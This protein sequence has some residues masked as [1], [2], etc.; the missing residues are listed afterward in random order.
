M[1]ARRLM[2]LARAVPETLLLVGTT[3]KVFASIKAARELLGGH[4]WSYDDADDPDS[5]PSGSAGGGGGRGDS[6]V[7]PNTAGGGGSLAGLGCNPGPDFWAD[8]L[9]TALAPDGPLP[10]AYCEITRLVSLHGEAGRVLV[11]CAARLGIQPGDA[12]NLG[13]GEPDGGAARVDLRPDDE[14]QAPWRRW[15]DLREAVVRHAHD[16][17]LALSSAA[18]AVA[19]AEDFMRWRYAGSPR[20]NEWVS[21]V[22]ELVRDARRSLGEAR[23]SVKLMR[24]A[25]VCQYFETWM[26]LNRA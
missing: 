19:A 22:R 1:E 3:E 14:A 26:I 16:A 5:P 11:L 12:H 13:G 24:D 2:D 6:G 9:A 21:A 18:S 23:D 20:R 4:T 10:E 15:K 25:V 8:L 17:L 7:S